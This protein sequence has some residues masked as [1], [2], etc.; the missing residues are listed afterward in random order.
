MYTGCEIVMGNLEI[1]MMEHNRDFSFLQVRL[2]PFT[3]LTDLQYES[4]RRATQ[5][6]P[7]WWQWISPSINARH[8]LWLTKQ[9]KTLPCHQEITFT[10]T[11]ANTNSMYGHFLLISLFSYLFSPWQS[12]REVTGYILLAVNEFSRLPLDNL[13]VIRGTMLY[14]N[15]YALA[16]M[17]NYQKDGQHGLQELGL[18]HLTGM[19]EVTQHVKCGRLGG[20]R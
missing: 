9:A 12:I 15:R 2:W 13:R 8:S 5:S 14:E 6:V 11:M 19:Q 4:L 17:V 3:P 7:V 1:S 10:I 18:T 20:R 16:V